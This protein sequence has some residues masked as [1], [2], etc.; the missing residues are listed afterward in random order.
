MCVS[1]YVCLHVHIL[2][3]FFSSFVGLFQPFGTSRASSR[4]VSYTFHR[5][6]ARDK[7]PNLFNGKWLGGSSVGPCSLGFPLLLLT[8]P[9]RQILITAVLS[10]PV[11]QA[12]ILSCIHSVS[13]C[14]LL[15]NDSTYRSEVSG[16][17]VLLTSF[18]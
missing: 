1:R 4:L 7:R 9:L 3:V 2:P 14:Q 15:A 12:I 16:C 13:A 6:A 18:F 10:L 17:L 5:Q 8:V 11:S